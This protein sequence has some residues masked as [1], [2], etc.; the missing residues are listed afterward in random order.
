MDQPGTLLY[1]KNFLPT[2]KK[3]LLNYKKIVYIYKENFFSAIKKFPGNYQKNFF[4]TIKK[5]SSELHKT[6]F[7]IFLFMF[8]LVWA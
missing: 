7:L 4:A 2:I 1:K 8:L 5:E 3:F 6:V